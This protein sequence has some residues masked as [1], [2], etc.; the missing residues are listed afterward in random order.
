M[1]EPRV[2]RAPASVRKPKRSKFTNTA[3]QGKPHKQNSTIHT[4]ILRSFSKFFNG[5]KCPVKVVSL[6][7]QESS[8]G[9]RAIP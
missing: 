6:I 5:S 9:V 2:L 3:V 8:F 1:M 7:L 4:D